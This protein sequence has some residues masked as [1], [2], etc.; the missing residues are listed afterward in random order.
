MQRIESS[1]KK[2]D[3]IL[4]FV[5]FFIWWFCFATRAYLKYT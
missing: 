1:N 5:C 4:D 3:A 2:A